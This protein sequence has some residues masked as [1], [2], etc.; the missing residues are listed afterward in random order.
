MSTIVT[1]ATTALLRAV[2]NIRVLSI[3]SLKFCQLSPFGQQRRVGIEPARSAVLKAVIRQEDERE[4]EE[5]HV[6]ARARAYC[7]GRV[8]RAAT[9]CGSSRSA[10][11][12]CPTG[13]RSGTTPTTITITLPIAAA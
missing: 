9:V 8:T 2:V 3:A 7:S 6:P 5:D 11:S 4:R 13:T 10:P 1:I 12:G